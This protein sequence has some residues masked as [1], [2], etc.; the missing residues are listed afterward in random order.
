[1][2]VLGFFSLAQNLFND[3]LIAL[4]NLFGGSDLPPF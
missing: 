2:S 3:E 1:V 4:P